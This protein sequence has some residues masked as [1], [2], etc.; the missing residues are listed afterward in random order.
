VERLDPA[1]PMAVFLV[2][3]G[4]Q[5]EP[6]SIRVFRSLY[7]QDYRQILFLSVGIYDYE[8]MDAGVGDAGYGDPEKAKHLKIKTRL[9]LDPYLDLAREMGLAAGC[10]VSVG[11][12]PVEEIDRMST[13]VAAIYSR[14]VFFVSKL[15]FRR[16]NWLYQLFQNG[17]A[18]AIRKRLQKKG[19]PVAVISLILP[20]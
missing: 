16:F 15:L 4:H 14:S 13:Q 2:G 18:E 11:T 7:A 1:L 17:T 12:D 10:R 8:V 6:A 3:G 19:F 5:L 20:I 9:A